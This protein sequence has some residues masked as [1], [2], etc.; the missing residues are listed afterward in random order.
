M[1][2]DPCKNQAESKPSAPAKEEV[3][4]ITENQEH[5]GEEKE[6]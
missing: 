1:D 3:P 4:A 6:Q 5:E 2:N